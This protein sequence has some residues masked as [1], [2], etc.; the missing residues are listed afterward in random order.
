[1]E[2]VRRSRFNAVL[3]TTYTQPLR[4]FALHHS[5]LPRSAHM[6]PRA[7]SPAYRCRL[8]HLACGVRARASPCCRLFSPLYSPLRQPTPHYRA[9]TGNAC[10]TT[11]AT[12]LL[13]RT[14]HP[15]TA[16]RNEL[17]LRTR[18]IC[19]PGFI[20]ALHTVPL[21]AMRTTPA[22]PSHA[23]LPAAYRQRA[24]RHTCPRRTGR[25]HPGVRT[26]RTTYV[27]HIRLLLTL[28]TTLFPSFGIPLPFCL[29]T[30][31]APTTAHNRLL[32]TATHAHDAP[33]RFTLPCRAP[34][35]CGTATCAYCPSRT[36]PR[37]VSRVLWAFV[38]MVDGSDSCGGWRTERYYATCLPR[39]VPT[40]H[41]H[42]PTPHAVP[43]ALLYARLL[44]CRPSACRLVYV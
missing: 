14:W 24:Y 7:F 16:Q 18:A 30:V 32:P 6:L 41:A 35:R 10:L 26:A 27:Y 37:S 17:L 36:H 22:P 33:Y 44:P 40:P 5:C 42:A 39:P 4:T 23:P 20:S 1:M 29:L 12:R 21:P 13:P 25:T 11:P 15:V 38:R 31:P 28:F 43:P 9:S 2:L 34:C 3:I 8:P 19:W